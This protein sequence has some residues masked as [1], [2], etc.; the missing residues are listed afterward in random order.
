M[1]STDPA[2][3]CPFAEPHAGA[4]DALGAPHLGA[5]TSGLRWR[6]PPWPCAAVLLVSPGQ[7]TRQTPHQPTCRPRGWRQTWPPARTHWQL[8][9]KPF[10][11]QAPCRRRTTHPKLAD[12]LH[13][14]LELLKRAL[15][16]APGPAQRAVRH[17]RQ[18]HVHPGQVPGLCLDLP[19]GA[20]QPVP[21]SSAQ[22][23]WRGTLRCQSS[24]CSM[25]QYCP[26]QGVAH[27]QLL[28]LAS[29]CRP[30][31]PASPVNCASYA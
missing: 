9:A 22:S 18:Q 17:S 10:R 14:G 6:R 3:P 2:R 7:L 15:F 25:D 12:S 1:K 13:V 27:T 11:P 31:E 19:G 8:H 21:S 29:L 26:V 20:R 4:C 30:A 16:H 23:D 24:L 5:C 28:P